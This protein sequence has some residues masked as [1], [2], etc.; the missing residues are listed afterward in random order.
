MVNVFGEVLTPIL[1][2]RGLSLAELEERAPRAAETLREDMTVDDGDRLTRPGVIPD[3][4]RAL[5]LSEEEQDRLLW[6]YYM[7]EFR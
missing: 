6:A 2:D 3:L 5:D 7:G 4:V 1:E